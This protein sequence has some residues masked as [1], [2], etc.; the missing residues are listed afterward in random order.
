MGSLTWLHSLSTMRR[1]VPSF[2]TFEW[3]YFRGFGISQ[4]YQRGLGI[5]NATLNQ[6]A[7]IW[8]LAKMT[9][10]QIRW[11]FE[12]TVVGSSRL[13]EL[14]SGLESM[15]KE[16]DKEFQH[17]SHFDINQ[18]IGHWNCQSIAIYRFLYIILQPSDWSFFNCAPPVLSS[19]SS[20]SQTSTGRSLCPSK[21]KDN[22]TR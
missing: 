10:P 19:R 2:G 21:I 11:A 6:G 7:K 4:K 20:A 22:Q 1:R 13:S 14:D 18:D 12:P 16:N 8:I 3:K 9:S 17:T 15:K 5:W